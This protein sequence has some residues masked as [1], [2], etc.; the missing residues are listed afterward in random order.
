MN[1]KKHV[2]NYLIISFILIGLFLFVFQSMAN[3]RVF[4]FKSTVKG[5]LVDID[6]VTW[7]DIDNMEYG[8]GNY[9]KTLVTLEN[10]SV[11][12]SI[13]KWFGKYY[14]DGAI[15]HEWIDCCFDEGDVYEFWYHD[16]E[17]GYESTASKS[18]TIHVIDGVTDVYGNTVWEATRS[19]FHFYDIGLFWYS[20]IVVG[21]F[22]WGFLVYLFYLEELKE[23]N[24]KSS[25]VK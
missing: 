24:I 21:G 8:Y 22:F 19:A 13:E 25:E 16:E 20:M 6:S 3:Y 17:R 2:K 5:E 7:D 4:S 23:P 10:E 9:P 11:G 14:F 1:W 18:Y 12:G 15:P